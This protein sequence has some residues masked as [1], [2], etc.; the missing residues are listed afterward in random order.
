MRLGA[1]EGRLGVGLVDQKGA[2][3]V[4]N[5]KGRVQ[6]EQAT[7]SAGQMNSRLWLV[8]SCGNQDT[9]LLRIAQRNEFICQGKPEIPVCWALFEFLTKSG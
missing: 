2:F 6:S 7:R 5:R 8:G 1:N 9:G 4:S 3:R